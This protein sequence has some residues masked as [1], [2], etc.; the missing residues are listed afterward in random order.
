VD[1]AE[2]AGVADLSVRFVNSDYWLGP[3]PRSFEE[4]FYSFDV[5]E[6]AEYRP[7]SIAAAILGV[8]GARELHPP[9]PSWWEWEA[10]WEQADRLIL[11]DRVYLFEE[12]GCWAQLALTCDCQLGDVLGL[13][14]AVRA[15]HPAVWLY[16]EDSRVFSPA[17]FVARWAA[18]QPRK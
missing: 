13:W 12:S 4:P 2:G 17:S 8:P 11:M 1:D 9:S 7:E 16:G 10:V 18:D 15:R 3:G 5:H 6:I 14:E